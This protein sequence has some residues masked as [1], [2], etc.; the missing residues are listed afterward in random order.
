VLT[1]HPVFAAPALG[2]DLLLWLP[3]QAG[4]QEADVAA[5]AE[6]VRRQLPQV[7]RPP[8]LLLQADRQAAAGCQG[9]DRGHPWCVCSL[10]LFCWPWHDDDKLKCRNMCQRHMSHRCQQKKHA[11]S[12]AQLQTYCVQHP[13]LHLLQRSWSAGDRQTAAWQQCPQPL[14][15]LRA[16]ML[17]SPT[18]SPP[19][20]STR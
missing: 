12:C 19:P 3:L 15:S 17:T 9:H 7:A 5:L 2:F 20:M 16:C 8:I 18:P 1:Q 13:K 10:P 4:K 11:C 14:T 6:G